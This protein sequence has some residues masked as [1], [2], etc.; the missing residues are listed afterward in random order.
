MNTVK[1][2]LAVIIAMFIVAC[3][4]IKDDEK[5][6]GNWHTKELSSTV[7]KQQF[8]D[9]IKNNDKTYLVTSYYIATTGTTKS[10]KTTTPFAMKNGV[11]I[12]VDSG[13]TIELIN[14]EIRFLGLG[15]K[16]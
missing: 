5:F 3:S 7:T 16:K 12:H 9:I 4:G 8:I 6:V 15:Y 11:L 10:G 1:N 13:T 2:I 14:D